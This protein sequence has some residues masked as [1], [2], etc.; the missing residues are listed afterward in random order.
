MPTAEQRAIRAER[1]SAPDRTRSLSPVRDV[2]RGSER[3]ASCGRVAHPTKPSPVLRVPHPSRVCLEPA[4][5]AVEG[6]GTPEALGCAPPIYPPGRM[7]ML[8]TM[9][10]T[11]QA[12]A[13][14]VVSF[15]TSHHSGR[16]KRNAS[17]VEIATPANA[18]LSRIAT[19]VSHVKSLG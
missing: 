15:T 6:W 9:R 16:L 5:S 14:P 18:M 8:M 11:A 1:V 13:I 2:L 12:A 7:M 17:G 10:A 3:R 19:R 4:L